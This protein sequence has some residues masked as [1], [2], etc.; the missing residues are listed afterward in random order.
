MG[1]LTYIH[2]QHLPKRGVLQFL[3]LAPSQAHASD[4]LD[5][6][7]NSKPLSRLSTPPHASACPL[8]GNHD[9]VETVLSLMMILTFTGG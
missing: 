2:H 6:H 3:A 4:K 8:I 7:H 1:D 9:L 5:L